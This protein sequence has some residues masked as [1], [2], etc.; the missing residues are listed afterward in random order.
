MRLYAIRFLT[1]ALCAYMTLVGTIQQSSAQEY[2]TGPPAKYIFLFIGDGMGIA[3]K[4]ATEAVTQ[5]KLAIDTLPVQGITT[6]QAND[7]FIIGS[8]AAGTA[9]ST[10]QITNIGMIGMSPEKKSIKSIAEIARDLG[11]KVGIVSSVSIDHATPAAFYAHVPKRS[12]YHYIDHAIATSGFDYFAGGG[13]KDPTGNRKGITSRGD[14]LRAIKN[15]GYTIVTTR[16][17]FDNLS[18]TSGKILASNEWLQDSGATPYEIDRRAQDVSLAE[19]TQQGITVLD[20]PN[21]FFLMVEGGKIDWA[22]HANDAKAAILDTVAF[23]NAVKEAIAFYKKHPDETLIVVTGDHETG[24][25]TLGFAGTKY[26][27]NFDILDAQSTS[28]KQ[29]TMSVMEPLQESANGSTCF[30]DIQPAITRYFGLKFEGNPDADNMVLKAHEIE[31]LNEAF[32]HSMAGKLITNS[33]PQAAV[34][35]GSYDPLVVAITHIV[36]NKAGLAWTSFKHTGTPIATS[37]IGVGAEQFANSYHQTA[38]AKKIMAVM[39]VQP[40]VHASSN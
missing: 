13:L 29:F 21:G 22:C 9:M 26:K 28:F 37:A 17:A 16:S 32:V 36:N 33:N 8:A 4:M 2:Y 1:L 35:Y 30:N 24:G 11:K 34:L 5:R 6:T 38:I 7:R 18:A 23:D 25:L 27:T 39:G 31:K 10:G 40:T 12:M 3:Q 20:N 19:F 14:A 15:A